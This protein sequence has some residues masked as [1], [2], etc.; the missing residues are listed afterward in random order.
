MTPA[1][2]VR[3]GH[4]VIV[5]LSVIPSRL[6]TKCNIYLYNIKLFK[7]YIKIFAIFWLLPPGHLCFTNTS[8]CSCCL[9]LFLFFCCVLF[10]FF[11]GGRGWGIPLDPTYKGEIQRYKSTH[12]ISRHFISATVYVPMH[13][14]NWSN[15]TNCIHNYGIR[16][17][18]CTSLSRHRTIDL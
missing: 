18:P 6:Q 8:S 14:Q 3:R 9:S 2:K 7:L 10:L 5:C 16:I 12:W 17:G 1:W 11:G 13:D 15:N 4:L